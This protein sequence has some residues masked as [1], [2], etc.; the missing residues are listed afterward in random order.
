MGIVAMG[1]TD[2][3]SFPLLGQTVN[4]SLNCKVMGIS[5]HKRQR[6][7][8]RYHVFFFSLS[9]LVPSYF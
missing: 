5:V 8:K 6:L 7:G 2:L 3:E 9:I 1:L 4:H